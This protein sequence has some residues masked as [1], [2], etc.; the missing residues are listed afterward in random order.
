MTRLSRRWSALL[1]PARVQR[2]ERFAGRF[3][4]RREDKALFVE[5]PAG[6]GVESLLEEW[7]IAEPRQQCARR[8]RQ[9]AERLELL[10]EFVPGHDVARQMQLVAQLAGEARVVCR[11]FEQRAGRRPAG[12]ASEVEKPFELTTQLGAL[13]LGQAQRSC[14]APRAQ[15]TRWVE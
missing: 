13:G 15:L 3:T 5:E 11:C 7:A 10:L 6:L 1:R 12:F 2:E 8:A 9:I 4:L 14:S